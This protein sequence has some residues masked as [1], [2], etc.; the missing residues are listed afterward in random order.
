MASDQRAFPVIAP[1]G[2]LRG[3]VCVD[4]VR[5][6]ARAAWADWTVAEIMTPVER[7]A[8]VPP[9]APA[10]RALELLEAQAVDQL[11]VVDGD[12]VVGLVRRQ[13]VLKWLTLNLDD[14]DLEAAGTARA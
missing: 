10:E 8:V 2:E 13:D 11:P 6:A 1:G 14:V 9:D 3:L 4:D 7:L 5:K 12:R